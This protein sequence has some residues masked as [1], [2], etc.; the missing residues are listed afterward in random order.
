M[1][2]AELIPKQQIVVPF[3]FLL[4]LVAKLPLTSLV[5]HKK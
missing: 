5:Q 2:C 3:E 1:K 4:T